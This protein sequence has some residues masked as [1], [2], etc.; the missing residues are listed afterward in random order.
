MQYRRIS[1]G[2]EVLYSG[3]RTSSPDF[4][5]GEARRAVVLELGLDFAYST[6]GGFTSY[7]R[8]VDTDRGVRVRLED[9]KEL[10]T[11][12]AHLVE[13]TEDST[14]KWDAARTKYE[15]QR[16]ARQAESDRR[17]A[18]RER[19]VA[20]GHDDVILD[21]RHVIIGTADALR[22]LERLERC[23]K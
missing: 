14:A 11:I 7:G 2:M 1:K 5:M 17:L 15:Q 8:R 12:A 18:L 23:R 4:R 9:G 16:A 10:V 19:F 21:N 3:D 6:S 13:L 20:L 22:L